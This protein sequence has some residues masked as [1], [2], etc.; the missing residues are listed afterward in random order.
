MRLSKLLTLTIV[1]LLVAVAG[2]S[3]WYT[4]PWESGANTVKDFDGDDPDLPPVM[5]A[6][7]QAEVVGGA[8]SAIAGLL[9]LEGVG[10]TAATSWH[11]ALSVGH[12]TEFAAWTSRGARRR[13][14]PRWRSSPRR[15]S[16]PASSSMPRSAR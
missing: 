13:S 10:D 16:S 11:E 14:S 4:A 1:S 2:P 8:M 9:L 7:H 6:G 3:L 15:A 5:C 12:E